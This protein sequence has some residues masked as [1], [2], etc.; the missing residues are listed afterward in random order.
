MKTPCVD[1]C[2]FDGRTGWCRACGRTKEECRAWKKAQPH[3]QRKIA[4]DLPRRL[5]K[6]GDTVLT[7]D[8][9]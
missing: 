1:I 9:D 7:L 6:L 5:R 8:R 3:Q 4:A 2:A